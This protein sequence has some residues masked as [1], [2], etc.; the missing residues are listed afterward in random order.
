MESGSRDAANSLPDEI[1]AKILSFL[2][3][4]RAAS[5]S[6]LS[7]RWRTLFP[8][9]LHLF[10]SD[11]HHLY[12]DDSDLLYHNEAEE[13][14]KREIGKDHL[15]QSFKLFVDK[16]LSGCNPI[17]KLSL[18][19]QHGFICFAL[20]DQWVRKAL[21]RGVVDL[22]LRLKTSLKLSLVRIFLFLVVYSLIHK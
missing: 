10:A 3:T 16:T 21:E 22:D 4:K 15:R 19:Y 12:L 5:T 14:G 20:T 1:L 9:M 7:K 2:P 11:Q 17:K 6:L 8:L 13:E 18:K